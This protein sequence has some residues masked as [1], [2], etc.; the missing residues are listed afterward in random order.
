VSILAYSLNPEDI[1]YLEI[2]CEGL[3]EYIFFVL[4]ILR[5]MS[6]FTPILCF[7]LVYTSIVALANARASSLLF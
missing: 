4:T 3:K 7:L 1:E 5:S 6:L 2:E